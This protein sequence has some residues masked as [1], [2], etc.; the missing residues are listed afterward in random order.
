MIRCVTESMTAACSTVIIGANSLQAGHR[1][2]RDGPLIRRKIWLC[3]SMVM[4]VRRFAK[5]EFPDTA[6]FQHGWEFT[7]WPV[8]KGFAL[9]AGLLL[10]WAYESQSIAFL[11]DID[12]LQDAAPVSS[13]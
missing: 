3:F 6:S 12:P 11:P 10:T 13:S 4:M 2:L 1:R 9:V 8:K 7:S 5:A